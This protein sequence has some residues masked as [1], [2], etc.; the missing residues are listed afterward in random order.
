MQKS[1]TNFIP[2]TSFQLHL[3]PLHFS[4]QLWAPSSCP[5]LPPAHAGLQKD[6][7]EGRSGRW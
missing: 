6:K 2:F 3:H 1:W 7:M 4:L 5:Y